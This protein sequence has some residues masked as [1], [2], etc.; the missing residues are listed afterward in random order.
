[1]FPFRDFCINSDFLRKNWN[2]QPIFVAAAID[3]E[4]VSGKRHGDIARRVA[5]EVRLRRRQDLGLDQEPEMFKALPTYKPLP[6]RRKR[7]LEG[8]IVLVGRPTFKEFMAG[9]KR[10]WTDGLE[11]VD[12]DEELAHVLEDD[13]HFDDVPEEPAGLSSVEDTSSLSSSSSEPRKMASGFP[14]V[15]NSPVFSPLQIHPS[16]TQTPPP[17]IQSGP[18]HTPFYSPPSVIPAQPPLLLVPFLDYIGFKQIPLMIWDFFNER[19]KVRSGAEAAYKVVM[20]ASGPLQV[21]EFS[22]RPETTPTSGG[23][24]PP[25]RGHLD[26]DRQVETFYNKSAHSIP[27]DI[28]KARQGY[29]DTLPKRLATARELARGFREPT[30]EEIHNPPPTEVELRAERLKKEQRWR[31]DFAGWDIVKPSH[32]VDWDER[33]RGTLRIF[34]D[35]PEDDEAENSPS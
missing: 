9:L 3:Y 13:A 28:E 32:D 12:R 2:L 19:R 15:Q 35:P 23:H 16:S 7:E 8:G 20:G 24:E 30:K 14:S 1:V 6:E 10:G 17:A 5:E 33:F 29:Y 25:A 27:D 31:S 34:I 22:E 26:F 21:P 4:L 11:K 18:R